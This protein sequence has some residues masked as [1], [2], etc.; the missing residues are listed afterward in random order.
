MAEE[1]P[2]HPQYDHLHDG[3]PKSTPNFLQRI[4]GGGP[5]LLDQAT[6]AMKKKRKAEQDILSKI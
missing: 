6:N 3:D 5:G 2:K 4:F 1:K